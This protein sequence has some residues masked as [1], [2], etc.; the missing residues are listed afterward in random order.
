MRM[1]NLKQ[2]LRGV[3]HNECGSVSTIEFVMTLPL[4]LVLMFSTV[5]S[6]V[7]LVQ[8]TM[9]ERALDVNVRKLRLGANMTQAE[10]GVAICDDVAIIADCQNS[11]TLELTVIDK[12]T[13]VMPSTQVACYN[14]QE[15]IVPVTNY[16][17]GV[18]SDLMMIRACV[19]VDPLFPLLGIGKAM[20]NTKNGDFTIS[21]RSAF[22]NEP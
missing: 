21:A 11:M 5:E 9:L 3:L 19:I 13:W 16:T 6:G 14:R 4:V 22:V 10:L 15:D 12:S 20:A 2:F 7:L 17:G 8:Q 18:D 1:I